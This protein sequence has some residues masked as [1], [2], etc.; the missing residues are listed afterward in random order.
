MHPEYTFQSRHFLIDNNYLHYIDEGEGPVIVLVHGNPTWSFFY[1][2]II[3]TLHQKFRLIALDN[4]GCGFSDKPQKYSYTLENHI[5]NLTAL[6]N[7]LN[8]DKCNLIV[9]DWGGAIGMG[10]A[11]RHIQ[12]I[13]KVII[14]NTAAFRSKRIPFRIRICRWP[15]IGALIVKGLNGFAWPATFMAVTK[16]MDLLTKNMYLHPYNSWKNRIAIHK[17]VK[18]IPL[19][20]NHISYQ[21]LVEIEK[22]LAKIKNAKTP[23]MILWG[24]R[25]FCFNKHFYE[26]WCERFPEAEA[27]YFADA[28]HYLLEDNFDDT[29]PLI[30]TFLT[31]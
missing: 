23:M 13:Q 1:R 2:K 24:G 15:F 28:G 19:T 3:Q 14:L 8:I 5:R 17:F 7:H 11:V 31:G 9:H 25:D 30:D 20:S 6:L 21:T 4:I 29:I 18:D 26:Q 10:Y 22:G 12:K 27:H 16:K